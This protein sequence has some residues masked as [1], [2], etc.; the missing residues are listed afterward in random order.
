MKPGGDYRRSFTEEGP[1]RPLIEGFKRVEPQEAHTRE[2]VVSRPRA[3][4]V[5][6]SG[7][8]G[9]STRSVLLIGV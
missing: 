4:G 2:I 8:D 6:R 9:R 7:R 1:C 3:P 5:M